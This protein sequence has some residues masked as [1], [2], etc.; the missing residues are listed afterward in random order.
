[1]HVYNAMFVHVHE[2]DWGQ[3]RTRSM[4]RWC[5]GVWGEHNSGKQG[6]NVVSRREATMAAVGGRRS[7]CGVVG[8]GGVGVACVWGS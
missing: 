3:G 5:V 1:M 4:G 2:G 7:A 6:I 8:G